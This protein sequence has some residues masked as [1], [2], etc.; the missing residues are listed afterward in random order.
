MLKDVCKGCM[1]REKVASF[2]EGVQ[3]GVAAPWSSNADEFMDDER[4]WAA[5]KVHC[6]HHRTEKTFE[7]AERTCLRRGALRVEETDDLP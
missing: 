2:V 3:Q 6:P 7:E 1:A 4:R 5:G